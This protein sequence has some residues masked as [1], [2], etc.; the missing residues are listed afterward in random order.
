MN[1]LFLNNILLCYISFT[2]KLYCTSK[3]FVRAYT[4]K[5]HKNNI[6]N[7]KYKHRKR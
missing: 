4:V 1:V 5:T 2:Y 7:V 3:I 6:Q